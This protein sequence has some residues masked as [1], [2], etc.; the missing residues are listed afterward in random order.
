MPLRMKIRDGDKA[1][2]DLVKVQG[3]CLSPW[4]PR[5]RYKA[6]RFA[7]RL[8]LSNEDARKLRETLLQ[9]VSSSEQ[10]EVAGR[11]E[12]GQRYHLDVDLTGP[13]GRGKVRSVWTVRTDENFPRLTTC[14]VI[15]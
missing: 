10:A 2:V 8:G 1:V 5:G 6:R 13:K 12:Y 3:Y 4:H 14:Y 15:E 7:I 11:D 9:A